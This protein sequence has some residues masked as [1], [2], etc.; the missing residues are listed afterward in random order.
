MARAADRNASPPPT[1]RRPGRPRDASLSARRQAEILDAATRLFANQGYAKTDVQLVADQLRIGK[2]TVYRYFPSK[3]SLFLAAVDHGM[4]RLKEHVDAAARRV[5]EPLDMVQ[6]GVRA[7]LAF[8]ARHPEVV[9][10]LIQERAYF[11]E[12]TTPTYWVHR[13]AN[14]GPWQELFRGL[15]R[16]GVIR[17]VPVD[18]ITDVL[19]DL[20]YGT[21]FTNY[22]SGQRQPPQRQAAAILDIVFHG[23]LVPSESRR[24]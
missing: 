14:V 12:R 16:A 17:K 1:A 22:F 11:R 5:D 3:E 23:L 20:L 13:Q 2:G 10:L 8:F 15:I 6:E 21:M 19:S 4:R 24:P 9:E 7:Y 18:R